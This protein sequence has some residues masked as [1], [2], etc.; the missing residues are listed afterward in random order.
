MS[1]RN[2]KRFAAQQMVGQL[3]VIAHNLLVW[4]RQW[5]APLCPKIASFGMVRDILHITG[6]IWLD[7]HK[8]I[9]R[10]ILNPVD[11]FAKQIQTGLAALLALEQVAVCLDEI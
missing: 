10:I 3:E 8:N 9:R 7:E 5:L 4:A 6:T 11:P 1:K 2:K